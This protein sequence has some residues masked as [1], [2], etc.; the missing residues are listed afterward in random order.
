MPL[1]EALNK[2]IPG[3]VIA[4]TSKTW[5]PMSFRIRSLPHLILVARPCAT[6]TLN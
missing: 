1:L 3:F 6:E 5:F 4:R 2:A